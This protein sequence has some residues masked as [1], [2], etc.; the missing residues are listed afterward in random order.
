MLQI[1][2]RNLEPRR[3][4]RD[5][6][7]T[8]LKDSIASRIRFR[9][10]ACAGLLSGA[11]IAAAATRETTP[12]FVGQGVLATSFSVGAIATAVNLVVVFKERADMRQID[13]GNSSQVRYAD[14]IPPD[15]R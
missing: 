1:L 14:G 11:L 15:H 5:L 6:S 13:A 9:I 7:D 10:G 8:E 3:R 2:E 12:D 4:I